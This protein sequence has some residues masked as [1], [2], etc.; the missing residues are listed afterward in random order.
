[1]KQ[2]CLQRMSTFVHL[3]EKVM[4]AEFP[5]FH[6]MASFKVF[7]LSCSQR[8]QQT[9]LNGDRHAA[10]QRLAQVI[11]VSAEFQQHQPLAEKIHRSEKL[12]AFDSWR[13]AV[14]K[15]G[16]NPTALIAV[17]AR[18]AC[19]S[20]SSCEVE[21]GFGHAKAVKLDGQSQDDHAEVEQDWVII[22]WAFPV[23]WLEASA[24]V[25]RRSVKVCSLVKIGARMVSKFAGGL[26]PPT[27]PS[28]AQASQDW[29]SWF[30]A[31][32]KRRS[33]RGG[34]SRVQCRS[35]FAKDAY[36]GGISH[37]ELDA[38]HAQHCQST[39]RPFGQESLGAD[40][41]PQ[42]PGHGGGWGT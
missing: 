10:L 39:E 28:K 2:R 37:P 38:T 40:Q 15:R 13:K 32:Q 18:C 6:V 21:R 35:C 20:A 8:S 25:G 27:E 31:G 26:Q 19:W 3:C 14:Q 34:Q 16:Q 41:G 23:K 4:E 5:S 7:S 29:R 33:R 1:M 24:A 12:N 17:L 9:L 11:S 30:S 22:L 42:A 36:A